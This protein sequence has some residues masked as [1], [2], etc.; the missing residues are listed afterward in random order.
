MVC[1]WCRTCTQ[2]VLILYSRCVDAERRQGQVEFKQ[3]VG[4]S[5][6]IKVCTSVCWAAHSPVVKCQLETCVIQRAFMRDLHMLFPSPSVCVCVCMLCEKT[7]QVINKC[8]CVTQSHTDGAWLTPVRFIHQTPQTM[9]QTERQTDD[10]ECVCVCEGVI[11]TVQKAAESE[12]SDRAY[13]HTHTHTFVWMQFE[14][15]F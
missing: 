5:L 13:T 7:C 14:T 3:R 8:V 10:C 1:W 15:H 6:Q 11:Q 2:H 9:T 12:Q 4:V